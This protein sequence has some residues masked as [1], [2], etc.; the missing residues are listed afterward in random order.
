MATK[1]PFRWIRESSQKRVLVFFII[2]SL[3]TMLLFQFFD[4][5]LKTDAAPFGIVSFQLAG[6]AANAFKIL[7]SWDNMATSYAIF[8]LGFDYLFMFL[9]VVAIGLGCVVVSQKFGEGKKFAASFGILLSWGMIVSGLADAI[10]NYAL[11]VIILKESWGILPE[12]AFI[13]AVV[14][15][16]FLLAGLLYVI[17]GSLIPGGTLKEKTII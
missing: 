11:T 4:A 7:N 1:H 8:G 12:I 5:P 14:K 15:F 10:E 9:Y 16:F 2:T 3:F 6:S 13:A 17:I